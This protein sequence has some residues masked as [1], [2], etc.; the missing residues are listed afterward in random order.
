MTRTHR[1]LSLSLLAV[2]ALAVS[3]QVPRSQPASAAPRTSGSGNALAALARL[4]VAGPASM[5]GFS[6]AQ[7]GPAWADIDHNGC[8]T[9][10][11]ILRRNLTGIA[12]RAGTGSCVV[13]SG[14]LADP[15]TATTVRYVRGHS[16]V[17]IDHL[18]ALG[19][20]WQTGAAT[21]T[22]A[23]R[24]TLANDPLNLLA[25]DDSANRQK[26]TRTPPL[27]SPPTHG[28]AA[29]TSRASSPSS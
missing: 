3:S 13:V 20:A 16:R 5:T 14:T 9:R 8:D 25:V 10:D 11:D 12:F 17:D 19:D 24:E 18:V 22:P 7:F 6:R 21:W 23:R 1:I 4:R 29:R 15:Y 28:F 26:G 27:G 2:A